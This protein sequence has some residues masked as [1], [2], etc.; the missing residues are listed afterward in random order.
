MLLYRHKQQMLARVAIVGFGTCAV[1]GSIAL[2]FGMAQE[3][4]FAT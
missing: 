4:V 1:L 2:R 3:E